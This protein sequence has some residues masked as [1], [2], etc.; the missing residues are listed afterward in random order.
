MS[1]ADFCYC[2]V[3]R[4]LSISHI[5]RLMTNGKREGVGVNRK[6]R[7]VRNSKGTLA[8]I[9]NDPARAKERTSTLQGFGDGREHSGNAPQVKEFAIAYMRDPSDR[10]VRIYLR[11]L[12][13][14]Q[15]HTLSI[16][17]FPPFLQQV[18]T[19]VRELS[20]HLGKYSESLRY[21]A[22]L[23]SRSGKLTNLAFECNVIASNCDA[24]KMDGTCVCHVINYCG[25]SETFAKTCSGVKV[26][27]IGPCASRQAVLPYIVAAGKMPCLVELHLDS[28]QIKRAHY[29]ALRKFCSLTLEGDKAFR[30]GTNIGSSI[31]GMGSVCPSSGTDVLKLAKCNRL[32]ELN[33]HVQ[34]LDV[35]LGLTKALSRLPWLCKLEIRSSGN[36]FEI[37]RRLCEG[38]ILAPARIQELSFH[39]V[40]I[41][42]SSVEELLKGLRWTLQC[43]RVPLMHSRES[44]SKRICRIFDICAASN[45]LLYDLEL[46]SDK[47]IDCDGNKRG[48][49][50]ELSALGSEIASYSLS[51]RRNVILSVN[52]SL[53]RLQRAN[54]GIFL[55]DIPCQVKA[56]LSANF[57]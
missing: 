5:L 14:R 7:F 4:K 49:C 1:P 56:I 22:G 35:F 53:R 20:L 48:D 47:E 39:N 21:V 43:L 30:H 41:P 38:I 36:R 50:V 13:Q 17:S 33:I 37:T 15:L 19:S 52:N 12:A 6:W 34:C 25:G 29:K 2:S 11:A 40:M 18:G 31:T 32:K 24:T 3:Q 8:A 55:H 57:S 16:D 45:R 9:R 26:L 27:K 44:P 51:Y 10:R 23:L 54:R 42:I 28:T 46:V